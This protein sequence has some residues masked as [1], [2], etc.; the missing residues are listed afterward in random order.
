MDEKSP[1]DKLAQLE[2][3]ATLGGGQAAIDKQHEAGKMTARERLALLFDPGSFRELDRFVTHRCTDFGMEHKKFL[4]DAVVTGYGT[5]NQRTVFAFAQDFTVY[6]GSLSKVVSE[7]ICKVMDLALQNGAPFVGLNDSGGARVQ[8]GVDSLAGYG[9]IFY[10]NTITSGVVPQISVILGPC[11]GGAVYSPAITDYIFMVDK[12]SHMFITGPGVIETVTGEKVSMD[13]LGGSA[14]HAGT[15]GVAH[16][17]MPDEQ[18]C[19]A[20]VRQL[21]SYFPSNNTE[22]S[23]AYAV[24]DPPDRED[25]AL[26]TLVPANPNQPYDVVELINRVVDTGSFLEAHAHYAMN[27]VVGYATLGGKAVGVVANNAMHKAGCLDI[28]ASMKGARHVRFCDAF[29]IPIVTFCDVPGF[30]PGVHQEHGGIIKHGAKM[31]YAYA[32]ATVPKVTV[33]L[34]KAYGGAY[35]VM[36]SKHLASDVNYT[37]PGAEIA[38]MGPDGAVNVVFRKEIGAAADP[39]ARRQELIAEYREKFANPYVAAGRGYVDEVIAPRATRRKLIEALR[40][41]GNK[42]DR[43]PPKKH[44]NIPL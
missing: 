10:R 37:Y 40:L 28:D 7:K 2:A 9:D 33:V 44:G 29:N 20:T 30:L 12:T 31:I 27:L 19:L 38:V 21:L 34:R 5:I 8:E 42:R 13:E 24:E 1:I 14:A 22:N 43:L 6:G 36:G 17:A 11:A 3:S 18:T 35:I 23:P 32:E 26:D 15:S 16:F 4:G 39:Q 41:L 25:A